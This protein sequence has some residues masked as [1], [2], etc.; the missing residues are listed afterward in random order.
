MELAEERQ[1]QRTPKN[2]RWWIPEEAAENARAGERNPNRRRRKPAGNM[3]VPGRAFPPAGRSRPPR[4]HAP[5]PTPACQR[6]GPGPKRNSASIIVAAKNPDRGVGRS[7][8]ENGHGGQPHRS[9][10]PNHVWSCGP[11]R[12][13]KWPKSGGADRARQRRGPAKRLRAMRAW[14]RPDPER[15][16][17]Q[18]VETR[19]RPAVGVNV[20]VDKNS[21]VV[22]SS[23][24]TVPAPDV[25][26]LARWSSANRF[27]GTQ[28][29]HSFR[30]GPD[31]GPGPGPSKPPPPLP[32]SNAKQRFRLRS[33]PQFPRWRP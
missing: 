14:R 6:R 1:S 10:R 31:L 3:P 15:R 26:R 18:G 23:L 16:K 30:K 9:D 21:I 8:P 2:A 20:E 27:I 11:M 17:D 12:S 32:G 4:E 22:R 29:K 7:F 28:R 33:S 25:D 13:P 19:S 5:G 24:A